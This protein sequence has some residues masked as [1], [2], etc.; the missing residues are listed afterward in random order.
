MCKSVGCFI[1]SNQ[2]NLL[3][4]LQIGDLVCKTVWN[5]V[6]VVSMVC[7]TKKAEKKLVNLAH[8]VYDII[9]GFGG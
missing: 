8:L 4:R 3:S 7:Q 9:G 2:D 6:M 1:Q 5:G